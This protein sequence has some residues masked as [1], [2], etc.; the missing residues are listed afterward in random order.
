MYIC[1]PKKRRHVGATISIAMRGKLR[2]LV[3]EVLADTPDITGVCAH[4]TLRERGVTAS[5]RQVQRH[6]AAL[7]QSPP[8]KPPGRL[9]DLTAIG[10]SAEAI[11]TEVLVALALRAYDEASQQK[12]PQAMVSATKVLAA[13]R[14]EDIQD[15]E[16]FAKLNAE[17]RAL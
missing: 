5:L 8:Q 11:T 1:D 6:V 12:K 15:S 14:G 10:I 7:R 16:D 17:I 4:R 9:A 2:G 13:V 3:A